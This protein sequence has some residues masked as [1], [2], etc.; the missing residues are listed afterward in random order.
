[1]EGGFAQ[2]AEAAPGCWIEGGKERQ[3][4]KCRMWGPAVDR[5]TA[6]AEGHFEGRIDKTYY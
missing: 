1:M 6:V 2:T 3:G 5:K 4:R